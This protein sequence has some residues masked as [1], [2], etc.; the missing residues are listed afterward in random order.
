[1]Q[2]L[3]GGPEPFEKFLKAY[4]QRFKF[5]SLTTDDFR[6]FFCDYFKDVP[7]I[8]DI[9]WD[10]WLYAPGTHTKRAC[11]CEHTL[12]GLVSL[13]HHNASSRLQST[14]AGEVSVYNYFCLTKQSSLCMSTYAGM[15]CPNSHCLHVRSQ[16]Y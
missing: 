7:A 6:A 13:V 5:K 4:L 1:M 16:T 11:S 2:T 8:G 3:V 14:Q 15:P 10:T 9:D 12:C